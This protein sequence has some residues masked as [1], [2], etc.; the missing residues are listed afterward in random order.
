MAEDKAHVHS[1]QFVRQ[2]GAALYLSALSLL[3][4]TF[5]SVPRSALQQSNTFLF[6]SLLILASIGF[7]CSPPRNLTDILT[8]GFPLKSLL[9]D[10]PPGCS[11]ALCTGSF[12]P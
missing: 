9:F 8:S 2:S 12:V 5:L 1:F 4:P 10:F 6:I 7:C 3:S 11:S